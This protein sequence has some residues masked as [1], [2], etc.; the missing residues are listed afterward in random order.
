MVSIYYKDFWAYNTTANVWTKK[1]DF[2]GVER[3]S[4]V[5][6][7][8]TC[9]DGYVG[10]GMVPC[11]VCPPCSTDCDVC[12]CGYD[13]LYYSDFWVYDVVN[14]KWIQMAYYDGGEI[15]GKRAAAVGFSLG[16]ASYFVGTGDDGSTSTSVTRYYKDFWKYVP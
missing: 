7:S 10:L 8:S 3:M 9:G 14:D 16:T 15:T 2:G 12:P 5:A 13:G 4:A 1:A 6:L 11:G